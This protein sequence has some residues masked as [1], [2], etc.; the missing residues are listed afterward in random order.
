MDESENL[1]S[2]KLNKENAANGTNEIVNRL[3]SLKAE[4]DN[5][6]K[7]YETAKKAYESNSNPKTLETYKQEFNKIR[8]RYEDKI[9]ELLT[10][11]TKEFDNL[12]KHSVSQWKMIDSISKDY[13][14]AH[15]YFDFSECGLTNLPD[16]SDDIDTLITKLQNMQEDSVKKID[17][18]NPTDKSNSLT[19]SHP[20]ELSG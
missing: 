16:I 18:L 9:S 2:A 13:C 4:Q 11:I 20:Y 17:N 19:T 14:D 3:K 6:K 1:E 8:T 5:F 7:D 10:S 12:K 15:F